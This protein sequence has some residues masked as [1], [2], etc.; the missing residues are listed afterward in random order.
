MY[1]FAVLTKRNFQCNTKVISHDN[2]YQTNA[3]ILQHGAALYRWW[4][5]KCVSCSMFTICS[6]YTH[7]MFTTCSLSIHHMPHYMFTICALYIHYMFS[8]YVLYSNGVLS[9]DRTLNL[10]HVKK[11]MYCSKLFF[12]WGF[13]LSPD[14]IWML[15]KYLLQLVTM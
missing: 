8:I 12:T 15:E 10:C 2:I 7:Q 6:L 1:L 9:I 4:T 14:I 11:W 13:N 5:W 3:E